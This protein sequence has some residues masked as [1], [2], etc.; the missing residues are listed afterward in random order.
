MLENLR[1]KGYYKFGGAISW[2]FGPMIIYY[3]LSAL[4]PNGYSSLGA[5]LFSFYL[6][7]ALIIIYFILSVIAVCDKKRTV[8]LS[9]N[10]FIDIG[11][12]IG[13]TAI[14]LAMNFPIILVLLTGKL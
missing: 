11:Y 12:I 6:L 5:G 13:F 2:I 1:S 8:P 9:M 14:I 4:L 3:F 7:I 10:K